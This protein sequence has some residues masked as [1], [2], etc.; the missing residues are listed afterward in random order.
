MLQGFCFQLWRVPGKCFLK[1][2]ILG[3]N[4][5]VL[6]AVPG[7]WSLAQCVYNL[8]AF[9]KD[10]TARRERLVAVKEKIRNS[11]VLNLYLNLWSE[12]ILPNWLIWYFSNEDEL[13][14]TLLHRGQA[15]THQLWS[16][17]FLQPTSGDP[18]WENQLWP[19]LVTGSKS[20]YIFSLSLSLMCKQ[21]FFMI[22]NW[23]VQ[24]SKKKKNATWL[25]LLKL[26]TLSTFYLLIHTYI[27]KKCY[28]IHTILWPVL[29]TFI[30]FYGRSA[31]RI[32][33]FF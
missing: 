23:E 27:Y 11:S 24:I 19:T 12:W 30:I 25:S 26:N 3:A 5:N 29:L 17:V 28:F 16:L 22:E 8:W 7:P 1:S 13:P 20:T 18:C 15:R 9:Q 10:R 14:H 21:S 33:M 32:R 4:L 31:K 2:L 6:K